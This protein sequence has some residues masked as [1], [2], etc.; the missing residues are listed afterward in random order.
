MNCRIR[1]SSEWG[2]RVEHERQYWE[3]SCFVRLSYDEDHL[4]K[5]N[6]VSKKELTGYIRRL[7]ERMAPSKL[8]YFAC[9]EYGEKT[10]RAH[11]HIILFG[12]GKRGWAGAR[13]EQSSD[14]G[15][16][17]KRRASSGKAGADKRKRRKY[18][19]HKCRWNGTC[20]DVLEGPLIDAWKDP[21][22]VAKG[23]VTL[24][25]VTYNSARYVS[26]YIL[27]SNFKLFTKDGYY[28]DGR[29]APF[30]LV[31]AGLGRAWCLDN[32][33]RIRRLGSIRYQGKE[34]GLPRYYA[35]VLGLTTEELEQM[36]LPQREKEVA[37]QKARGAT[38]ETVHR[39]V[40]ADNR[41]KQRNA[42][43]RERINGTVRD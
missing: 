11:Y 8:K 13:A 5:N 19:E 10:G 23:F 40:L 39:W 3:D 6:S 9:G 22:G 4:P 30:Q 20:L 16:V 27:K 17:P 15:T 33:A 43:A 21:Y 38:D 26:G 12:I 34:I 2:I 32:A 36:A 24:G 7:R 25:T 41:Q 18:Y 31:S 1:R 37:K 28:A 35:K 42:E 29:L 14:L